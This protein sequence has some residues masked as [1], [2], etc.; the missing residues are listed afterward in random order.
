MLEIVLGVNKA[1][2]RVL[3]K[4]SKI[5]YD[6]TPIQC[7]IFHECS[8]MNPTFLLSYSST[9]VNKN[10]V[11]VTAWGRF[12]YITD[13]TLAPGGRIYLTCA[14][15]VLMS[16][17]EKILKLTAY[18][19]RSESSNERYIID[20][21]IPSKVSI[22]RTHIPFNSPFTEWGWNYLLTVKGG[23]L[24]TPSGGE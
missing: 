14:E 18:A 8:V 7:E 6:Q 17:K 20:P 3:D 13:V 16:N 5:T 2:H 10:Y 1:D 12:Y 23:K 11:K 19:D 15:D 9:I 21:K 22:Y 24:S 4:T